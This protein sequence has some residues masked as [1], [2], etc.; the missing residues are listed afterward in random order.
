MGYPE[1]LRGMSVGTPGFP[2]TACVWM[3]GIL[4]DRHGTGRA[5]RRGPHPLRAPRL[6]RDH[7]QGLSRRRWT[8]EELL[9]PE[10][11]AAAVI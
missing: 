8:P 11:P 7:A 3:R 10:S 6:R 9:A 1:D 5:R 2:L 4:A